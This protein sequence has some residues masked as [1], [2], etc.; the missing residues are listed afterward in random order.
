MNS[1]KG[2]I[3]NTVTCLNLLAGAIACIL[4]FHLQQELAYGLLGYQWAFIAIGVAAIFDF[5]DGALARVLHAY[6]D[7]GKQ[8]D[9]LSD[10][11]SFGLAPSF[12]MYNYIYANTNNPFMS[13]VALW[14]VVMGALRLAKFNIDERQTTSFVG[15]PIPA[16]ALFWIGAVA[17]LMH[18]GYPG[19]IAIDLL[20]IAF[21]L[22]MVSELK[23]FSLKFTNLKLSENLHR[24]VLAVACILFLIFLGVPGLALTI[25]FYIA[26]AVFIKP[27]KT[28]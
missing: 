12:L 11:I 6:S 4:S 23:I 14:I 3:P 13:A 17:W 1:I 2:Y 7:L 16:N 20:V 5:L 21:P 15:L 26:L 18:T 19:N 28:N 8:L 9:S 10:L 27:G 24:Y 25:I 22:L